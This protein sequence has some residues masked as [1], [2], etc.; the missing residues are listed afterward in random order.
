MNYSILVDRI[1]NGPLRLL[2]TVG[3]FISFPV[4]S[5]QRCF[6]LYHP[7]GAKFEGGILEPFNTESKEVALSY[8]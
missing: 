2:E 1:P 8:L 3:P 4:H 7:Q 6:K 5:S